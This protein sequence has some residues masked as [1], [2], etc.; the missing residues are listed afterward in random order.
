VVERDVARAHVMD[1]AM[2]NK[3]MRWGGLHKRRCGAKTRRG[4]KCMRRELFKNGVAGTMAACA[5]GQRRRRGS[6]AS[7]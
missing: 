5:L 7:R 1:L 6:G 3:P 2:A 4:T